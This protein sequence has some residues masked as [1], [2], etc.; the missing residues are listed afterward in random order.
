MK[1][2]FEDEDCTIFHGHCEDVLPTLVTDSVD[3]VLM[4]PPYGVQYVSNHRSWL[5][6]H[7]AVP[8]AGDDRLPVEI[9]AD[10]EP[11]LRDTGAV[12]MFCTEDGITPFNEVAKAVGLT[13]RRTL[14][15]DKKNWASGDLKGDWASQCEFIPWA[16][17]GRHLL[18][19]GRPSNLLSYARE[20]A[21]TRVV[22][23]SCQKPVDLLEKILLTSSDKGDLI[24]D[25]YMGSGSTLVAAKALGRK[26]IG[27]ELDERYCAIAVDR[28]AQ[29]VF[30]L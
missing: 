2:Y 6:E 23:H 20:V 4:D 28:L 17:K 10:I 8:I 12:Y 15:W 22:Y 19:G 21:A 27:C 13:K 3:V 1:P 29:G 26:S 7:I 9:L 18:R 14:I 11:L 24:L 25:P 30:A 5:T 16:A